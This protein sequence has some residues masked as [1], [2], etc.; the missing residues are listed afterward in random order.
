MI[1]KK[2][3]ILDCLTQKISASTLRDPIS[4][5]LDICFF[6]GRK[7]LHTS[8]YNNSASIDLCSKDEYMELRFVGNRL[9]NIGAK[10][11]KRCKNFV[12]NDQKLRLHKNIR[13]LN[14]N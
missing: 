6:L 14:L 2:T 10:K 4:L 11:I 3:E 9:Y 7:I 12:K 1:K 13:L 8:L 5:T